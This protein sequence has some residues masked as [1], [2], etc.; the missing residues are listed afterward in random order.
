MA[1]DI[2]AKF[3]DTRVAQAREN[4]LWP[5]ALMRRADID[6]ELARLGTGEAGEDGRRESLVV[7]PSAVEPGRGLA[8][9]IDVTF[10]VLNPGEKSRPRRRNAVDLGMGVGGKGQVTIG[11]ETYEVGDRDVW[12]TPTMLAVTIE[13]RGDEPFRYVSYSNTPILQKLEVF[14]E[15]FNPP[16]PRTDTGAIVGSPIDGA[17]PKRA[18][19]LSPAIMLEEGG[20]QL[21]TYEHLVDPDFSNSRPVLW[22]WSEVEGH[23]D[24]VRSLGKDYSGRPL[25]CLYNPATGARNGT[26][27]TMFATFA[28]Y[29]PDKVDTPHRHS[30]AAINY[31]MDGGGWSI[32]NG[33]RFEWEAGDI[34][35]SAPGWGPHGHASGPQGT[36]ILTVQDHPFHIATESLVWQENLTDAPIVSLGTDAGFQTN[37]AQV[38]NN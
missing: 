2:S 4:D 12:T 32:V 26:T 6:R 15:E 3:I 35:L 18:K 25:F 36:T 29:P 1:D 31:I 38:I 20:G 16:L 8:P 23:A 30:S 11:T 13:N 37:L 7:H 24:Q 14:Y 33:V 19:D 22:R 9:G 21:L 34:M 27:A 10:G 28:F 17:R 5:A